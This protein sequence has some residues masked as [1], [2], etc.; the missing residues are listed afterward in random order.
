MSPVGMSVRGDFR[1]RYER[2]EGVGARMGSDMQARPIDEL[3]GVAVECPAL[4]QL[5]S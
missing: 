4:D 2:L 3:L 1:V 5:L